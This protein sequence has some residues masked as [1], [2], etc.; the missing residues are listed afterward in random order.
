ADGDFGH[1]VLPLAY[2]V[3]YWN[4]IGWEDP[5]S[6]AQWSRR[7]ERYAGVLRAGRLYTPQLVVEGRVHTVGSREGEVRRLIREALARPRPAKVEVSATASGDTELR[8][9][10]GATLDGAVDGPQELLVAL[11]ED[12]LDTKV[13]S[14]ENAHRNLRND[15]VV[16]ALERATSVDGSRG[17][18]GEGDVVFTLDPQWPLA[19]LQVVAFLQDRDSLEIQGAAATPVAR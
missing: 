13:Q 8:V 2:H 1:R 5:F 11:V 16:R 10:A 7:Q 14:G 6:S 4:S 15:H 3:D 17:A 18:H 12:G 9:H 19:K